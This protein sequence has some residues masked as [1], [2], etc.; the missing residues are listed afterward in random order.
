MLPI[1]SIALASGPKV[2]SKSGERREKEENSEKRRDSREE[3]GKRREKR[4]ER[5][6]K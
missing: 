6:E 5:S 4:E 3:R 1:A 2:N